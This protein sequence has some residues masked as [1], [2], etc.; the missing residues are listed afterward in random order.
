MPEPPPELPPELVGGLV[1]VT[2]VRGAGDPL[3]VSVFVVLLLG[4]G[5]VFGLGLGLTTEF[6]TVSTLFCGGIE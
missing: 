2:G 3:L 5:L 4:M 1:L 6:I